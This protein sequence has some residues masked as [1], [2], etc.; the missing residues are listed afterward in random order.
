MNLLEIILDPETLYQRQTFNI[1]V[2]SES[3]RITFELRYLFK[4]G[5]WYFS[6]YDAQS[7]EPLCTYVPLVASYG[8]INDLLE[9]FGY[10]DIGHMA[11]IPAV[12]EPSSQ[13]PGQY[14]LSEFRLIW[15]DSFAA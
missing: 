9:P 10:K 14:N 7:S 4:P 5:K 12:D 8:Q 11:C 2:G 3:K 1:D 13:D 6:F 15:G